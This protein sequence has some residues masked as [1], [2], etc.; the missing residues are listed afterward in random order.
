MKRIL[1]GVP[2]IIALMLGVTVLCAVTS[3]APEWITTHFVGSF[4]SAWFAV[5]KTIICFILFLASMVLSFEGLMA[6]L[7]INRW[8]W[9]SVP[10]S[11]NRTQT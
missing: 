7:R 1:V 2:L 4:Q 10:C 11:S 9:A 6:A 8:L 3:Q 5:I